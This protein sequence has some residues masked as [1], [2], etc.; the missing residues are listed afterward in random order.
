MK[1]YNAVMLD[2]ETFGCG[3]NA[4]IVQLAVQPFNSATGEFDKRDGT[5]W[6]VNLDSSQ[7]AGGRVDAST[8]A[9][10]VGQARVGNAMPDGQGQQVEVVLRELGE[11]FA[12]RK[13]T[14]WS[15]GANFDIPIVDGYCQRLGIR[16]PWRYSAA[17]DTRTIY[18]LAAEKGWQKSPGEPSHDALEDCWRQIEELSD[19]LKVVR[20]TSNEV[21]AGIIYDFVGHQT[22]REDR[23][24]ADFLSLRGRNP[25]CDAKLDWR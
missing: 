3:I 20:G 25:N 11:F 1:Q 7:R 8:I 5:K 10:W 12:G 24:V 21:V 13:W 17:R 19:A 23:L 9:W 14:V 4:A 16:S 2:L 22:S 15:Q 18:E 6:H